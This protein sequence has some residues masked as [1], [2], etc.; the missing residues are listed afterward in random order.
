MIEYVSHS[1]TEENKTPISTTL[2]TLM[3]E[4]PQTP[5]FFM[6]RNKSNDQHLGQKEKKKSPNQNIQL[7]GFR[8]G[9]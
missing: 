1:F 8:Y 4:L 2:I 7:N 9:F 6:P 3:R 5:K